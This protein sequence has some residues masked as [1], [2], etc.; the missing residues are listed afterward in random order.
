[1]AQAEKYQNEIEAG[2]RN[3]QADVDKDK[4]DELI[5]AVMERAGV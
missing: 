1:M 3:L 2:K 5:V 4:I